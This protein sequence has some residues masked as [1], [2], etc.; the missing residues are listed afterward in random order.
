[1]SR[2]KRVGSVCVGLWE[3]FIEPVFFFFTLIL[4]FWGRGIRDDTLACV[5]GFRT[6]KGKKKGDRRTDR[7]ADGRTDR[8]EREQRNGMAWMCWTRG[9]RR[10][11]AIDRSVASGGRGGDGGGLVSLVRVRSG[12]VRSGRVGS[13]PSRG[14]LAYVRP[15][16]APRPRP[17]PPSPPP[18]PLAGSGFLSYS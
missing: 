5:V 8:E 2:V 6:G 18:P 3:L 15:A 7:Q 14:R 16:C 10:A 1:M 11:G 17:P 4:L 9:A 13:G 12:Q